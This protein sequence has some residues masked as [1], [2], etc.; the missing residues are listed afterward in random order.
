MLKRKPRFLFLT[1]F[2]WT[3][4]WV[5][6]LI[7]ILIPLRKLV[8]AFGKDRG[9]E[10]VVPL[11]NQDELRRS[12]RIANALKLAVKYSPRSANCYP[13]AL[14]ARYLLKRAQVPHGLFFGLRRENDE[15]K[16]HAWVH[17]G[18]VAVTGGHSFEHYTV[19]RSFL[20]DAKT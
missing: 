10:A 16:A 4:L 1:G 17:V 14:V 11:A 2:A 8:K 5:A 3:A 15:M 12:I 9:T 7:I 20:S 19:V 18:P 13:Q 6:R